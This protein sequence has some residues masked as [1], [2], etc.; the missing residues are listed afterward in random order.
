MKTINNYTT[1]GLSEKSFSEIISLLKNFP[2]IEQA[3]IFGSRATGNYKTGSDIDIAIFGKNVNQ[4]SI[5]NLMDAFED[6]ILP[7]FVDVLDY[8]T[9]KNIELKKHIDEAGVEFYRKKTNYQ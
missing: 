7:Y 5:L 8:K 9:I 2:E 1:F 6:S 4:K 3:K